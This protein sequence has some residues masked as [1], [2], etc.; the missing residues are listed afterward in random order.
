MLS[1]VIDPPSKKAFGP[2]ENPFNRGPDAYSIKDLLAVVESRKD[3]RRKEG[4]VCVLIG[5]VWWT[6]KESAFLAEA[7]KYV[8]PFDDNDFFDGAVEGYYVRAPV[9]P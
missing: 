9:S 3:P 7:R 8:D 4:T 2:S 5:D 6:M 1:C